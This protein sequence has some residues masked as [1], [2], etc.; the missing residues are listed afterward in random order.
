VIPIEPSSEARRS[1]LLT[2]AV[3]DYFHATALNPLIASHH[4]TRFESRVAENTKRALDLLDEFDLRA[5]FFVLG[6]VAEREPGIVAE[7][8]QR[9]H[10]VASKGFHHRSLHQMSRNE[11]R[12]DAIRSRTAV[13]Q[14]ASRPVL[15][16][17]VP[18]GNFGLDDLWA[19]EVLAEAGY[20][21]DSSI[22][23]AFRSIAAEPWRRFPHV[24]RCA[25][26]DIIE[27]PISSWGPDGF[28]LR[29]AGGNYLRQLPP[30]LM[31]RA[32]AHW[33]RLYRSPFNMYFH[34]WELDPSLP[35]IAS[36]GPLTRVRQYRNLKKM[37]E[38]LRWYFRRYPFRG[39]ADLVD[40]G[41]ALALEFE[42]P[43]RPAPEEPRESG[44][45][46]LSVD[47]RPAVTIVV[48]CFNEELV[49]PYLSNTLEELQGAL[50]RD[51]RVRY[52]LVDDASTDGTWDSLV[53]LLGSNPDF[54]LARHDQNRG[55]AAAILT[56]IRGAETEIVCSI[57]CDCSYDP[58]QLSAMIPLLE[59][60]VAMVTAS[61]YHPL[62]AVT[63][64][65]GPRLLLSKGLS[66]L[67]RRVLH[68]RLATYTSCFRVYR[69]SQV[70]DLELHHGGFLGVAE[71]L[72]VLD[73]D[74]ARVVECPAVLEARVL[75]RSKMSTLAT[76]F[77][78]LG[79]LARFAVRRVFGPAPRGNARPAAD[80]R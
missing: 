68:Q 53:R 76:I 34:V 6:W 77:G 37:P 30:G 79:L 27:F 17:R 39:I 7:I 21:Y 36:A 11:F 15:G 5:T 56:G 12:E 52:L 42:P 40:S 60:N 4:W 44:S 16:Y 51:Y 22:Y 29:A 49:L 57:D 62:G 47:S 69:R 61:P 32:F 73:L 1:H 58:H 63:N 35:R 8:V 54:D 14:A 3:E 65:T 80:A 10:E 19:L 31:Q 48:P 41:E 66:A 33:D 64:V 24:Q 13:E 50:M 26:G 70:A 72:A 43:S 67:Y 18:Q 45:P 55:V 74:G 75:G 25:A 71:L 59:E 9:G 78:H 38:L 2:V 23:P 46:A 20:A 28:L